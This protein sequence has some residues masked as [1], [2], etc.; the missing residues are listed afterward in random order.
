MSCI[1]GNVAGVKAGIHELASGTAE[2]ENVAKTT[3]GTLESQQ[4]TCDSGTDDKL[5]WLSL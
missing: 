3:G 2:C 1:A 4:Q 5:L